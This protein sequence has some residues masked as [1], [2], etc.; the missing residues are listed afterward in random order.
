[1]AA[2]LRIALLTAGSAGNCLKVDGDCNVQ[3]FVFVPSTTQ[4]ETN[5]TGYILETAEEY[6]SRVGF[7][8]GVTL[9][10]TIEISFLVVLCFAV[11]FSYRSMRRPIR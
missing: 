10:D 2:C 8:E 7:F 4:T 9:A 11:A 3:A 5:C 6:Q 1:M